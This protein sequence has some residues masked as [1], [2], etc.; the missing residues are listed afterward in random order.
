MLSFD[1]SG[2][3]RSTLYRDVYKSRAGATAEAREVFVGGAR[4]AD[5]W[6]ARE[7]FT[8]LELGFGLGVNFL[9]TLEA[10]RADQRRC[11]RLHFV[12]IEGH[13]L[14]AAALQRAHDALGIAGDDA[15]HLRERW[16]PLTPGLHRIEFDA[17]RVT[18]TIAIGD[19]GAL[20]P[21]L[22]IGADAFYLDGFA[23]DRNPAMWSTAVMKGLARLANPQAT[24][25]TYS[26]AGSVRAALEAAGFQTELHPGFGGKRHRL[27]ARYAP[28]WRSY[29][30]PPQTPPW[31]A[32]EAIVVGGGLAGCA[33]A[34]ALARRGWQVTLLERQRAL[35]SGGSGQPVVADHL[36]VSPDD[37]PLAR[38]TRAALLLAGLDPGGARQRVRTVGKLALADD[39]ANE[40][41]QHETARVLGFPPAL[42][43]AVDRGQAS[44]LAGVALRNGG[45]WM[46]AC[47]VG[48]PARLCE[49]WIASAGAAVRVLTGVV[50]DR[51]DQVDG[52]WNAI[53]AQ[54]RPIARAPIAVLA[55][56]GDAFRA[57]GLPG[58]PLRRVRG[59][60]TLVGAPVLAGLRTVIGG[61]AYAC[62]LPG[63]QALV[64]STFD[65]GE[66]LAPE[67]AA[68][69]S[70]LRRLALMLDCADP[71]DAW[72]AA[73]IGAVRGAATGLRYVA[74]DRLPLIGA[75]PDVAACRAQAAALTRNARLP[76]PTL[77]GLYGA[78]GFG[79][80]GLLWASLAAESI[81][82]A[83]DGEPPVLE[84][85]LLGAIDPGRFLRHALRHGRVPR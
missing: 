69:L 56:A 57:A 1:D 11:A 55:N 61:A 73:A 40:Q 17:G 51:L 25:A 78:F 81:G 44:D 84:A 31:P 41:R 34:A 50:V 3:P 71:P 38:L 43:Q 60:T 79:S 66:S 64:G 30:A 9:V 16:P 39:G 83:V 76:L 5:R 70:N 23:P 59:Q 54:G 24:L 68:D 67:P 77:C 46:P 27:Q 18:L 36:H 45:L 15:R 37:N 53:D 2:Q 10:W 13:P 62:P 12:S 20:L 80:R 58:P 48:T 28:R 65:D 72:A 74:R 7:R 33:S 21:R 47:R 85:D 32:R 22:A 4:A 35:A 75:I 42:L 82:A 6:H 14:Q 52:L 26:A 8:V 49:G 19:V 63:D 29:P